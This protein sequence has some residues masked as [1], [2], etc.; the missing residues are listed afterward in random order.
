MKLG[1]VGLGKMGGNM[2]LRLVVGS[3]DG[4]VKGEHQVVGFARDPNPELAKVAGVTLVDSI[5]SL[6]QKLQP[7]RVVWVMVPHGAPTRDTVAK[8]AETVSTI[9][10]TAADVSIAAREINSGANDLAKRTEEQ[11]SALEETTST[12]ETPIPVTI[13]SIRVTNGGSGYTS[14]PTVTKP[15]T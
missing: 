10:A 14:A 2:V 15:W 3:P 4:K 12:T 8:L 13:A 5:E 11:A 9:Q 1:M 7:P 6:A